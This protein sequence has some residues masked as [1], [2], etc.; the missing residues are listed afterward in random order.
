MFESRIE[1][2]EKSKVLALSGDLTVSN[3][4]LFKIT[5]IDAMKNADNL[6]LNLT[7]IT[8]ADISCL[9]IVCSAHKKA[10]NSNRSIIIDDNPSI[11]F[12]DALRNSGFL[13]QKG[14][15]S[16]MHGRCLLTG[17]KNA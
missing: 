13:R 3:A 1:D 4:E 5:L 6:V 8:G 7:G 9:Q 2:N 17:E 15:L 12:K 10:I 14:C 16:D 11:I